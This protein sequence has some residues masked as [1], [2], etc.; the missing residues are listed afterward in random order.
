M[1][2]ISLILFLPIVIY[3]PALALGQVTNL[4]THLITPIVCG[5]CIFYTTLG[6]LKAVVWTDVI[7]FG[8]MLASM[9]TVFIVGIR[10]DGGF[11]NV[12]KNSYYGGRLDISYE[13]D[14]L[15]RDTFWAVFF[16]QTVQMA[17][18]FSVSQSAVQKFMSLPAFNT[19]KIA[20]VWAMIGM[21]V[22][23]SLSIF[24]GLLMYSNYMNCDPV[25][26]NL[27]KTNDQILP[28]YV[29]EQVNFIPGLCGLFIS[30]IF[31]AG[32]STLSA[33]MNCLSATLYED[34][35]SPFVPKNTSEKRVSQYLK[36]IVV[37]IGI[38]STALVYVVEKLGSLVALTLSFAGITSGPILGL[39][40]VGMLLPQVT[41]KG[42]LSG[43]IVS[44]CTMAW[45][46]LTA[47]WYKTKGIIAYP[48]LPVSTSGCNKTLINASVNNMFIN[49]TNLPTTLDDAEPFAIY[50]VSFYWY[51]T[52]G[53]LI[54][55]I[56][57]L[58]VSCFTKEDKPLKRSCISPIMQFL[59]VEN[60]DKPPQYDEVTELENLS[61]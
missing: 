44:L 56:V 18:Y 4:N 30:G 31:S 53:L 19:I 5:V 33:I 3:I 1:Y 17:S 60:G 38:T 16:G 59:I 43:S 49:T 26:A 6:G 58:A 39:F 2:A 50:R 34:F 47:Q 46:I 35:I 36:L 9:L 15:Q 21:S 14:F 61:T 28:F 41:A 11:T 52:M 32:L 54:N 40:C 29:M 27:I 12:I 7:Q 22:I 45:V 51:S 48:S 25:G 20:L 55:V 23:I 24:S 57:S 8:V 37:I 13:L 42:A 10:K